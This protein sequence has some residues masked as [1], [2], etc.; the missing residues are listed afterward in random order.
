MRS[1]NELLVLDVCFQGLPRRSDSPNAAT[2]RR[3]HASIRTMLN[4]PGAEVLSVR[5]LHLLFAKRLDRLREEWIEVKT[6]DRRMKV[7]R[8]I[9]EKRN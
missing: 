7:K 4:G 5:V 6:R 3:H 1:A 9:R 8:A 2:Q